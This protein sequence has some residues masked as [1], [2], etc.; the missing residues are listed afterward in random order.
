MVNLTKKKI[1]II[2]LLLVGVAIVAAFEMRS[3]SPV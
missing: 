1:S 2:L 3:K